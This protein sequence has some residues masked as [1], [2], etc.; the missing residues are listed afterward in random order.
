MLKKKLFLHLNNAVSVFLS[1]YNSTEKL[2]LNFLI[3]I[4]YPNLKDEY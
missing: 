4:D 1:Y 2:H 3:Y